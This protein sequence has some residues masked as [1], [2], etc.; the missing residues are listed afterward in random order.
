VNPAIDD[1][2]IDPACGSGGFLVEALRDV[3]KK[4]EDCGAQYGWP[5]SGITSE[6]QEIAIKNFRGIDKDKFL[7]KVCQSIHGDYR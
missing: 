7:S 6:K 5:D 3:W 2:V 1:K 4:V